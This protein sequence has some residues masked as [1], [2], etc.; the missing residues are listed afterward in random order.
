MERSREPAEALQPDAQSSSDDAEA[1]LLPRGSVRTGAQAGS[2]HATAREYRKGA[3]VVFAG[4]A[5][6]VVAAV[7]TSLNTGGYHPPASGASRPQSSVDVRGDAVELVAADDDPIWGC[8][9]LGK[10]PGISADGVAVPETQRLIDGIKSSS[11]FGKVSYWNWNLAPESTEDGEEFLTK[12]FIF[13]PEVWGAGSVEE[14]YLRTAGEANFLDSNGQTSPAEMATILLGSNEP[15][16]KGSCMGN[17]FGKCTAPCTDAEAGSGDCPAANLDISL[18]PAQPNAAG[19]CNCWEFSHATG[20]GFWPL[21]GCDGPQPLPKMWDDPACITSVIAKWKLT[22]VSAFRKGYKYLSTPLV[23]VDVD[24]AK[25]F[26][27]AAC[28]C[29]GGNC[30]CTDVSC[31]CPVYIGVHFYAYDC[32]P[33]EAGGYVDFQRK[34]QAVADVMETYPFVKGAIMNEVGMLNCAPVDEEPICV[35]NGGQFPATADPDGGCPNNVELPNGLATFVDKLF[36]LLLQS[37]TSDGRAVVKGFSWFNE[38]M[39]GGTYNLQ[40]FSTNG[41]VNKVGEAYIRGCER[42]GQA[43]REAGYVFSA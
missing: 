13:M 32:R 9:L 19:H 17:M 4:V 1:A 23:A 21:E 12:D 33:V 22:A 26:I 20:V 2:A 41:S 6:M 34:L 37:K 8:G 11:T 3:T 29:V 30:A 40:L 5:L 24:H 43:A 36:D 28:E 31:G 14:Q 15:D 35:P 10:I 16:I 25:K 39:A 38:N 42:W 18:P 27:E 7:L